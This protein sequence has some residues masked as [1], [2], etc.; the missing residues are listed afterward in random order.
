MLKGQ[1]VKA[2]RGKSAGS[3]G[4]VFWVG[5]RY[6][7]ERCGFKT[8]GGQTCWA[9]VHDCVVID[10]TIKQAGGKKKSMGPRRFARIPV[11]R[12]TA[13]AVR[14]G[15]EW[16]PKSQ[17]YS[18]GNGW[19]CATEWIIRQ[20]YDGVIPQCWLTAQ[21]KEAW[22][23]AHVMVNDLPVSIAEQYD[24][25]LEAS[26]TSTEKTVASLQPAPGSWAATAR[27]M[28]GSNPSPEEG[29][30]WDAWKEER[31]EA[32][33]SGDTEALLEAIYLD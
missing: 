25:E 21:Q 1:T 11:E 31:K 2:I 9:M 3:E 7:Q 32:E 4:V 10:E 30:F 14:A 27:A 13:K 5:V 15:G 26:P 29:E 16:W 24:A 18:A 33:W 28:A 20:K 17:A 8:A 19:L 22:E 12:Q 23:E 6:E